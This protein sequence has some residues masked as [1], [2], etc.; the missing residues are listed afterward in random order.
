M[1]R[2]FAISVLLSGT[3][4]SALADPLS[5]TN[6]K[7]LI[8][9]QSAST[10]YAPSGRFGNS[11]FANQLSGIRVEL[12]TVQHADEGAADLDSIRDPEKGAIGRRRASHGS[13]TT[14]DAF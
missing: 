14:P 11:K 6:N 2:L 7:A 1:P 5:V 3:R 4:S 8:T 10:T 12:E 9:G 13:P